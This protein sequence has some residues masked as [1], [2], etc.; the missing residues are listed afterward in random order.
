MKTKITVVLVEDHDI[1]REGVKSLL[2]GI[3]EIE[4]I[5]ETNN[6]KDAI[7]IIETKLPDIVFMDIKLPKINGINVINHLRKKNK[8]T[9]F[10]IL[11][12]YNENEYIRASFKAG[13]NGFLSKSSNAAELEVA[14]RNILNDKTYIC[15][16]ISSKMV[17]SFVNVDHVSSCETNKWAPLTR[18]ET[19]IINLIADGH[20]NKQIS[21]NLCISVKTVDTHRS[22]MMRKLDLH[23]VSALTT[24]VLKKR[25][26]L[27]MLSL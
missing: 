5:G 20:S 18:R 13:A 6:G 2:T 15:S 25:Q 23:S 10:L 24:Y 16:E 12:G 11:S 3:D 7:S 19:E 8:S 17:D 9:K 14:I 22:N 4:I 21:K 26:K 1:V 27:E